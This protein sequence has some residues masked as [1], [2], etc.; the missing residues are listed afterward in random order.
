MRV[1]RVIVT[2]PADNHLPVRDVIE[3]WDHS[4]VAELIKDLGPRWVGWNIA[5]E[6]ADV[7][8]GATHDARDA[9]VGVNGGRGW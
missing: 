3:L 2:D 1:T 9:D 4:D 8:Y 6:F 5:V 7:S